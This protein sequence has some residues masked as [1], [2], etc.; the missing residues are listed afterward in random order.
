MKK[1]TY[2]NKPNGIGGR[3]NRVRKLQAKTTKRLAE[4]LETEAGKRRFSLEH[5]REYDPT[6]TLVVGLLASRL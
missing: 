6:N 5:F 3:G 2:R 1:D 4:P